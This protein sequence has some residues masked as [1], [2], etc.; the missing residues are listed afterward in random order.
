MC[1]LLS[2]GPWPSRAAG[3][4]TLRS[5]LKRRTR[6]HKT[7]FAPGLAL[8]SSVTAHSLCASISSCIRWGKSSFLAHSGHAGAEVSA[9]M[10]CP[11][12]PVAVSPQQHK[13]AWAL[14][15]RR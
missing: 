5:V 11:Q 7:G 4:L 15:I 10:Q 3:P 6:S 2:P 8:S 13:F 1:A 12:E 9:Y 14:C